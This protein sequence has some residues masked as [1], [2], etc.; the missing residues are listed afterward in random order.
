MDTARNTG[1]SSLLATSLVQEAEAANA[2]PIV[3]AHQSDVQKDQLR[4][5]GP[6]TVL[7]FH[8]MRFF[9]NLFF[10]AMKTGFAIKQTMP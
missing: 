8:R 7:S 1:V 2:L 5:G 9:L 6:S 10:R 4:A 3:T